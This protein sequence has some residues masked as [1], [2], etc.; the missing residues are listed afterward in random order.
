[1]I[2]D[3]TILQATM[4]VVARRAPGSGKQSPLL[5]DRVVVISSGQLG[6]QR[7]TG[8]HPRINAVE[9]GCRDTLTPSGG[10]S[11]WLMTLEHTRDT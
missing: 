9:S 10:R 6:S 8:R 1:M 5:L 3:G 7:I 11:N 4:A 2:V